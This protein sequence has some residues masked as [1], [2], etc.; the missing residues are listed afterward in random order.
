QQWFGYTGMVLAF[1]VGIGAVINKVLVARNWMFIS[2]LMLACGLGG[3]GGVLMWVME[4]SLWFVLAMIPV[5]M[6]YGIAIPNILARAL[7]RYK[8]GAGT[9]GAILGLMYYTMLGGGLVLAGLTQRLSLVLVLSSLLMGL[10]ALSI[11]RGERRTSIE[12]IGD[13]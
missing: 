11:A 3:L 10:M 4:N 2:L 5:V 12:N 8:D 13:I 1:G 7:R 6:A 9:A